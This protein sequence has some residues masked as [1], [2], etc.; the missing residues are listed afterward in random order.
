MNT[1]VLVA[2]HLSSH[3]S[4]L[5][6]A[7]FIMRDLRLLFYYLLMVCVA[8]LWLGEGV[9]GGLAGHYAAVPHRSG[10]GLQILRLKS[11]VPRSGREERI[12]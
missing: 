1:R 4:S 11:A 2:G 7:L 8:L 3:M 10:G 9:Y 5:L 6:R 12:C